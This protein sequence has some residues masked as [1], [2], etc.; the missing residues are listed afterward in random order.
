MLHTE[1]N[2]LLANPNSLV[3]MPRRTNET[4]AFGMVEAVDIQH[5]R[6]DDR[7][8]AKCRLGAP[9]PSLT[10]PSYWLRT[11]LPES[12]L[13]STQQKSLT[14]ISLQLL[15]ISNDLPG[16]EG[17][18][19]FLNFQYRVGGQRFMTFYDVHSLP[20]IEALYQWH[21]AR[22]T[23]TLLCKRGK[24][25]I[26]GRLPIFEKWVITDKFASRSPYGAVS[27][28]VLLA[29]ELVGELGEQFSDGRP[30]HYCVVSGGETFGAFFDSAKG[31]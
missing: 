14:E 17:F 29:L 3:Y 1:L 26:E 15:F 9:S 20:V 21:A 25:H 18:N 23:P 28:C 31:V 4:L 10:Q 30:T 22:F 24:V 5:P 2:T 8:S 7:G 12:A 6:Y 13:R 16:E 27:R 19:Y 11:V